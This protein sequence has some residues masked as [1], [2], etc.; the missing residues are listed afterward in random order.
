[1]TH[2]PTLFAAASTRLQELHRTRDPATRLLWGLG[3]LLVLSG[4]AH[5]VVWL[6]TGAAPLD[7]P[8]SWRKPIVFGLSG[9]VTTLSLAWLVSLVPASPARTRWSRIYAGTM[10]L[11]ILLIDL[12][13]WRG[14]GSHFNVATPLDTTI[15]NVMGILIVTATVATVALAL[16]LAR[17][18]S[19]DP[20]VRHAGVF[21]VGLLVVGGVIGGL[22]VAHGSYLLAAGT[23]VP[24]VIGA[25]ILKVPHAVALHGIQVL[26]FLA[27]VLAQYGVPVARRSSTVQY[28]ALGMLLLVA[29]TLVQALTG[30]APTDLPVI[31][32]VIA[33][34][35]LGLLVVPSLLA[36][37]GALPRRAEVG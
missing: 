22:I 9:G 32:L 2:S 5:V 27:W 21:G 12:Q 37:V 13:R 30:H 31:S 26:P 16:Q 24:G 34:V 25:G 10:A 28:A 14:V 18:R 4:L 23:G 8:V 1:M 35:G 36:L 29:A 20:D 7:G 33:I 6:A 19:V 17:A 3:L 11:E 15:F